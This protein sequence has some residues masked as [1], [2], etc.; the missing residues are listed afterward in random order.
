MATLRAD[1][2][3]RISGI[4]TFFADGDIWIGSMPNARKALDLRRDARYALHSGSQDPPGWPGDAKL[5]GR[6]EE[7]TDQERRLE[8]F[9]RRDSD[10]PSSDS[11]L[12]RLDVDEAALIGLNEPRDRLAIHLWR[13][14]RPLRQ[15][16]RQPCASHG[17]RSSEG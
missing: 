4:E 14:E 1:G 2:S 17:C 6:A 15:I 10:P 5:S 9:R 3:R 12:F 11:H 8:L 13:P 7:I 16:E